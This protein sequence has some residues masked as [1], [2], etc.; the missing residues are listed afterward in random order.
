MR[1]CRVYLG[2]D[3]AYR[4][5]QLL[6][7][8]GTEPRALTILA[9]TSALTPFL[10]FPCHALSLAEAVTGGEPRIVRSLRPRCRFLLAFTRFSRPRYRLERA[11]FA[12]CPDEVAVAIDVHGSEDQDKDA[13]LP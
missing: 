9:G 13:Y 2:P 8:T 11:T 7:R 12:G 6:R 3:A 5:L 1:V 4:F 10:F